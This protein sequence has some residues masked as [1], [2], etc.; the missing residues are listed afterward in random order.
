MAG[1]IGQEYQARYEKNP[2]LSPSDVQDLQPLVDK[3]I[4]Y[5][6]KSNAEPD[7]CDLLLEIEQLPKIEKYTDKRNYNRVCLYLTNVAKYMLDPENHEI[8]TVVYNIYRNL[9]K[10]PEAMLVALKMG[11][12]KKIK[13]T[14]DSCKDG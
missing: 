11:D 7:A 3:I 2:D 4:P 8:L 6:I 13:D 5:M 9:N 12:K 1:E 14:F 10:F